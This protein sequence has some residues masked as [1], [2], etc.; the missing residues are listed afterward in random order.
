RYDSG[1]LQASI[2]RSEFRRS[3]SSTCR[4]FIRTVFCGSNPRNVYLAS[5][6]G[7]STDSRM[8]AVSDLSRMEEKISIGS[9]LVAI[10]KY[11]SF[12][13]RVVESSCPKAIP[14][15]TRHAFEH[16]S[17]IY[18]LRDHICNSEC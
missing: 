15:A 17:R 12:D 16:V 11:L 4:L 7:P 6:R 5:R 10:G 9:L 3:N 14:H 1:A 2:R 8:N 18:S 13:D